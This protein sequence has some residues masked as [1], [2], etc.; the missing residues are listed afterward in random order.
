M[1]IWVV[2]AFIALVAA[3]AIATVQKGY[4]LALVAAGLALYLLPAVFQLT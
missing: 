1:H 4:A 3:C 2:L